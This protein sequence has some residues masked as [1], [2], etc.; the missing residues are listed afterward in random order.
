MTNPRDILLCHYRYDALDRLTSNERPNEPEHQ[1]FYCKSRLATEIQGAN[2]YSVF[3]HEDQLLAQQQ[4]ESGSSDTTLLVTDQQRSVLHALKGNH[5]R[6]SIAYS[7]YGYRPA[8]NGLL[9]LLGFNGERQ[10]PVTGCYLLGNGYR[11]FNPVLMRFNSPDS[12]S[13]FGE[14]GLN[15]YA[16]CMGKPVNSS[17]PSGHSPLLTTI[18]KSLFKFDGNYASRSYSSR[19]DLR[20]YPVKNRRL[21]APDLT[22]P[23]LT[24]PDFLGY[25]GTSKSDVKKLLRE[26]AQPH[27]SKIEERPGFYLTPDKGIAK[28]Y[29][30]S[31]QFQSTGDDTWNLGKANIVEV[32][33]QNLQGKTPGRDYEFNYYSFD[34]QNP[35]H[36]TMEFI[37]KPHISRAVVIRQLGSTASQKKAR[38]RAFEAP[39]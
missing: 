29:A 30:N 15:P 34:H 16:Y 11:A 18:L 24:E 14:G 19:F 2:R 22:I 37:A 8:E 32:H 25:H 4:R 31:A 38:P 3:Q 28:E 9:S 36:M 35:N 12:W 1:R 7:P 13:P 20:P 39:F 23:S 21:S 5:S 26:G 10:D 6:Q 33:I 27:Y 17:D